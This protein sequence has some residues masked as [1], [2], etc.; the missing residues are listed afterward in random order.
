MCC[1]K[2]QRFI[3]GKICSLIFWYAYESNF[4]RTHNI[5]VQM[6]WF[7]SPANMSPGSTHRGLSFHSR[8]GG[9]GGSVFLRKQNCTPI[10]QENKLYFD[11]LRKKTVPSWKEKCTPLTWGTFTRAGSIWMAGQSAFRW[12]ESVEDVLKSAILSPSNFFK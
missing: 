6:F 3:Q 11:I 10:F 8:G 4:L 2:N 9:G 12:S 1:G 5:N 7:P